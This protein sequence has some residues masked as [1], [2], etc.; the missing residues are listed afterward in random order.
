MK[1]FERLSASRCLRQRA[2]C[3]QR[4]AAHLSIIQEMWR[5]RDCI[6]PSTG[7]MLIEKHSMSPESRTLTAS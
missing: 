5:D 3:V 6:S 7:H 4:I 1:V 2:L